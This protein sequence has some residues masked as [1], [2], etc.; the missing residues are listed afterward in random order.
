[1]I[2]QLGRNLAKSECLRTKDFNT[3]IEELTP[4][5]KQG[6]QKT[7]QKL[8]DFLHGERKKIET[9]KEML[10]EQGRV[11]KPPG[12]A[13]LKAEILAGLKERE[14][15]VA[16]SLREFHVEQE[17]LRAILKRLLA[18]GEGVRVKDLK[19]AVAAIHVQSDG[20][21]KKIHEV[22]EELRRAA[23]NVSVQWQGLLHTDQGESRKDREETETAWRG[24]RAP[25]RATRTEG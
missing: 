7:K 9:L 8:G 21:A 10:G 6:E 17:E 11:K 1:M 12:F 22:L 3:I 20:R 25:M 2:G 15:E 18:K 5:R 16:Q 13:F 23:E 19:A 14:R 4:Y 24:L